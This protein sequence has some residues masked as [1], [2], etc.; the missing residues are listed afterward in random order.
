[1]K[2]ENAVISV[3]SLEFSIL[4]FVLTSKTDRVAGNILTLCILF[5]ILPSFRRC[6]S[7][8]ERNEIVPPFGSQVCDSI[9]AISRVNIFTQSLVH[10]KILVW[11]FF[12][13][14]GIETMLSNHFL[15]SR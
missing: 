5:S 6:A 9:G 8:N 12:V 14:L 7:E 1:M 15:K 2:K 4:I 13:I 3:Q 10:L 11:I